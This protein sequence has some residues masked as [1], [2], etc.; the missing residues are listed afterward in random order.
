MQGLRS[1]VTA[2]ILGIAVT[3]VL[4]QQRADGRNSRVC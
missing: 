2:C 3:G 1:L 4:F